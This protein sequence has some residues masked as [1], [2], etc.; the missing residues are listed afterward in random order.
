LSDRAALIPIA[1]KYIARRSPDTPQVITLVGGP[2]TPEGTW[3]D[4]LATLRHLL[5]GYAATG[6]VTPAS[7]AA[8]HAYLDIVAA[9]L[10]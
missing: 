5:N 8:T 3:D 2:G 4:H 7:V 6:T 10:G 1:G 9:T